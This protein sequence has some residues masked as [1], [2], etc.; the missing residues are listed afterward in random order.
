VTTHKV[1][2]RTHMS[3]WTE[4][5]DGESEETSSWILRFANRVLS[6]KKS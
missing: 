5:L 2:G 1:I 4:M 6:Q 3:V